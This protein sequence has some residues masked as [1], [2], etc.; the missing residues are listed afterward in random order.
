MQ[1]RNLV[2]IIVLLMENI[3]QRAANYNKITHNLSL[4][5]LLSNLLQQ[6]S[7]ALKIKGRHD[8]FSEMYYCCYST[9]AKIPYF[10]PLL[11]VA[12]KSIPKSI[13]NVYSVS[14]SGCSLVHCTSGAR[15][16][17]RAA[18]RSQ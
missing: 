8:F 9:V 13:L 18:Q 16:A 2:I 4:N 11:Y 7:E 5:S 6:L 17:A 12:V 14:Q 3:N 15:T 10:E 1:D